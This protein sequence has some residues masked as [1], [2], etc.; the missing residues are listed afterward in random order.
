MTKKVWFQIGIAIL[1]T[2]IIIKLFIE[3]NFIFTPLF[4]IIK[5]IILPV[6][7]GGAL[8]YLAEPIQRKLEEM[9]V[10]RWGSILIILLGV[11]IAISIVVT[12]L[13]PKINEQINN[14]IE[15][16]PVFT[17]KLNE[18]RLY[19]V[20]QV[21]HLPDQVK[22]ALQNG[23]STIQ[24][25]ANKIGGSIIHFIQSVTSAIVSL[26]LVPFFFIFMLKDHEKFAPRIYGIFKRNLRS[27]IKQTLA[28]VNDVLKSYIQGQMIIS[29][30]LATLLFIG[31]FLVG[32]EYALLLAI[33][34]LFMNV[35]PFLGPWI[36]FVPAATIAL[37][38]D[39]K[40]IIWVSIITLT[41]QQIDS[42]LITPNVMGKS[43][44]IHPLTVIALLLAAGSIAGFFGIL[45]AIPTYAVI[46]VIVRNIY[47]RREL[48]KD[49]M[50]E[51]VDSA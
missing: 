5:T 14:L 13:L 16:F 50:T 20:D 22:D 3:I 46:K 44:N 51:D 23:I 42:H 38:Q 27:W 15:S 34:A 36:A 45:L 43:L 17:E 49:T 4:I 29:S 24:S 39:P 47:I 28:D 10:P 8:F 12:I 21:D 9:K 40:L 25:S 41:A 26:I 18:W 11:A 30:L 32:L 1:L 48:I 6:I 35:I 33:F 2:L 7:F 31:Y 37:I 19:I